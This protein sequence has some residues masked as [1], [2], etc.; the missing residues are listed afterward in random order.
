MLESIRKWLRANCFFVVTII[1]YT[2]FLTKVL[3]H[4]A[5]FNFLKLISLDEYAFIISLENIHNGL[6]L[7]SVKKLF[8]FGF[9]HYGRLYFYL[10][11]AVTFPFLMVKNYE[12]VLIV[13]KGVS[14]IF[15]V[16]TIGVL[17]RFYRARL[18]SV[19][20]TL[21]LL[22]LLILPGFI[23]VSGWFHPDTMM[24]LFVAIG[25]WFCFRD[26]FTYK[27]EYYWGIF[28][29]SLAFAVKTQALMFMV[30]PF[31]YTLHPVL[32]CRSSRVFYSFFKRMF[33]AIFMP[34]IVFIFGNPQVLH[35]LGRN[36]LAES[37]VSSFQHSDQVLSFSA[38]LLLFSRDYFSLI[39]LAV[40]AL[41]IFIM[42]RSGK[43]YLFECYV[44]VSLIV[45]FVVLMAKPF[46]LTHY[47]FPI[48]VM[49]MF[50]FPVVWQELKRNRTVVLVLLVSLEFI[51]HL[52]PYR[53]LFID[54]YERGKY[55]V[56]DQEFVSYTNSLFK[57]YT[58]SSILHYERIPLDLDT[59]GVPITRTVYVSS[60]CVDGRLDSDFL[61]NPKT[62]ENCFP[63]RPDLFY[64]KDALILN[65]S[66][67]PDLI[68]RLN[69]QYYP[70]KLIGSYDDYRFYIHLAKL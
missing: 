22:P 1:L 40:T 20:A 64:Q 66:Q 57:P 5:N 60:Y 54:S 31:L 13:A 38:K 67:T 28:C 12:A 23:R 47:F 21:G 15:T 29:F 24:T 43:K 14:L 35:P 42:F 33:V 3:V 30:F 68:G 45:L 8:S 46:V 11:Y 17:F 25:L 70:Y 56:Y 49:A 19:D 51:L 59:L 7:G 2:F 44:S 16:S 63:D 4:F 6:L 26:S 58:L 36:T 18:S 50:I 55:I 41:A 37:L 32:F 48:A 62:F 10:I 9:Y 27:R 39:W 69:N 53:S 61:I 52:S 65:Q 34:V